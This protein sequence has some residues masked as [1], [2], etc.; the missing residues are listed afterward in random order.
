MTAQPLAPVI[1]SSRGPAA[2]QVHRALGWRACNPHRIPTTG[3]RLVASVSTAPVIA[4]VVWFYPPGADEGLGC[5]RV[6]A[7]LGQAGGRFAMMLAAARVIHRS[8]SPR[9]IR[10]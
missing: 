8:W 9:K 6:G 10:S 7:G 5:Y 1:P 2:R 3:Q 4:L